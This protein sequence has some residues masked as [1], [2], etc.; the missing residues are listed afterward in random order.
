MPEIDKL[1]EWY[2]FYTGS[3]AWVATTSVST[4]IPNVG[5]R[6]GA[7]FGLW[8]TGSSLSRFASFALA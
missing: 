7:N 2:G 1:P 4:P 8:F 6:T 5:W 3:Q